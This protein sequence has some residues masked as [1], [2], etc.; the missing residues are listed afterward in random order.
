MLHNVITR[1]LHA[2]R[3]ATKRRSRPEAA[4]LQRA[5]DILFAADS[6]SRAV[7]GGSLSFSEVRTSA[8]AVHLRTEVGWISI[9]PGAPSTAL[10][11]QKPPVGQDVPRVTARKLSRAKGAFVVF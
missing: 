5:I 10:L 7:G 8:G 1:L 6:L 4:A 11:K 9:S 2:Q 3:R